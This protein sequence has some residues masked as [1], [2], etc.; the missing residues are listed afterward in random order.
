[1]DHCCYQ[2]KFDSSYI[3]LLLYVDDMLIAGSDIQEIN[4][5]KKQ[6]SSEFEMKDL[7]AAKKI[8]GMSIA[9]N[10][11]TGTLKLSQAKYIRKVL[12]KFSM[13]DAKPRSTPWAVN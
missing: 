2:K 3:I 4:R 5:L 7:G 1:M 11:E 9:R 12:E 13:A 6:L 8:L 10:K